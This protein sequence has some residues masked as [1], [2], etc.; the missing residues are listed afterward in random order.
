LPD[1]FQ[2]SAENVVEETL[3]NAYKRYANDNLARK[4]FLVTLMK[5]AFAQILGGNFNPRALPSALSQSIEDNR[6]FLY[7]VNQSMQEGNEKTRIAGSLNEFKNNEYRVVI[8]NTDASKLD[9]Y[10]DREIN[11]ESLTCSPERK[12]QVTVYLK[13]RVLNAE[14]LPAYVL[15]RADVDKPNVIVSGQHRFKVFIYGP[16]KSELIGGSLGSGAE[17]KARTATERGRP[18]FI[19]DIDLA[20]DA[21]EIIVAQF[22]GGEGGLKLIKQPLVRPEIVK[23][24]DKC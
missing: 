24:T 19:E 9:Y 2:I 16:Y 23:I 4:E 14:E 21:S 3:K 7:L 1:G 13:N 20:P 17:G 15:I 8:Q 11:L 5:T 12:T 10:L 18:I 22:R 6:L